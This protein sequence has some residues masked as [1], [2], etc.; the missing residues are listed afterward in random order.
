MPAHSPGERRQDFDRRPDDG[1]Q[2][3]PFQAAA[4]GSADPGVV[5]GLEYPERVAAGSLGGIKRR[6]GLD[7]QLRRGAF[8]EQRDPDRSTELVRA[9]T[10]TDRLVQNLDDCPR[11]L[12]NPLQIEMRR[13]QDG[14][15]V[16]ADSGDQLAPRAYAAQAPGR[17]LEALVTRGVAGG[18]VDLLESSR[19]TSSSALGGV[20]SALEAH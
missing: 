20:R 5:A 13:Q 2:R 17:L 8:V 9:A 1:V 4:R 12:G 18:V 16:A 3:G 6:V 11:N 19:S 14:E 10:A 7:E 15:F